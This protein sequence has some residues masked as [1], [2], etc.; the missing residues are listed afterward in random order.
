MGRLSTEVVIFNFEARLSTA[1]NGSYSQGLIHRKQLLGVAVAPTGKP[2][3]RAIGTRKKGRTGSVLR[4]IVSR[5]NLVAK[6]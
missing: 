1:L 2:P 4:S 3:S 6:I 5:T